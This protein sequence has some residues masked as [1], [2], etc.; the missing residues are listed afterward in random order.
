MFC[1]FNN[2]PG[3]MT[4]LII[5]FLTLL[6]WPIFNFRF[7]RIYR[8]YLQTPNAESDTKIIAAMNHEASMDS[9]NESELKVTR[10]T[11]NFAKDDYS[12]WVNIHYRLYKI[13]TLLTLLYAVALCYI[14]EPLVGQ[15]LTE[16]ES[17]ALGVLTVFLVFGFNLL[18]CVGRWISRHCF[19]C[20]FAGI[21]VLT[22]FL[23]GC[24]PPL[25]A[26]WWV[27]GAIAAHLLSRFAYYGHELGRRG[28]RF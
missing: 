28:I 11:G 15:K 20:L 10:A 27:N 13:I 25:H 23:M 4:S 5:L 6:L 2:G 14:V 17:F 22:V 18:V 7:F 16:K 26:V 9:L 19:L 12:M 8:Q 3:D 21:A 24:I 1:A